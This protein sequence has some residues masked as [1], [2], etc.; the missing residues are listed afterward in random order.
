LVSI[1]T[2]RRV[3]SVINVLY[4]TNFMKEI[5]K[6]LKVAMIKGM[7]LKLTKN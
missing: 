6:I 1:K 3:F 7:K 4:L 5:P 2:T